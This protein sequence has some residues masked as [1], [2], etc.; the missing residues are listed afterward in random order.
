MANRLHFAYFCG[1]AVD[2]TLVDVAAEPR[3]FTLHDF[4]GPPIPLCST[5]GSGAGAGSYSF[6]FL[7]EPQDCL[8]QQV[9]GPSK[10]SPDLVE[11]LS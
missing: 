2:S 5:L 10:P 7:M 9:A 1:E 8:P 4:A 3:V 11:A 6:T